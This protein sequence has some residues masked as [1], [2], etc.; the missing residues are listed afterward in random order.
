M[1]NNVRTFTGK[2]NSSVSLRYKCGEI[3]EIF[4]IVQHVYFMLQSFIALEWSSATF[5]KKIL[6]VC[7]F[8]VNLKERKTNHF[9]IYIVLSNR[10]SDHCGTNISNSSWKL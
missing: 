10:N 1:H 4:F 8:K 6:I 5:F 7:T 9:H 2:I 3:L